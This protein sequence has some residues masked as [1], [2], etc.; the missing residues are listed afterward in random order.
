MR[1]V[2]YEY[3]GQDR[4]PVIGPNRPGTTLELV[5]VP[6]DSPVRII[7]ADRLRPSRYEYPT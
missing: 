6:V 1:F 3:D 2:E 4:L 5:A 7:H